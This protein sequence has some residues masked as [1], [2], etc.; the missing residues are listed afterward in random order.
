MDIYKS[1]LAIVVALFL[2][3]PASTEAQDLD[4]GR[5]N[6]DVITVWHRLGIPQGIGR[7]KKFRD[8]RV[9]RNGNRPEKERKPPLKRLADEQFLAED[10]NPLLKEAAKIKMDQDLAP[11]K[12]KALKYISSVGCS[13]YNKATA[14]MLEKALVAGME[15][16]SDEVRVAAVNVV[17]SN[18][19]NACQCNGQC[20]TCCSK[21]IVAK[22]QEIAFK[23]KPDG[24]FVEPNQQVRSLAE[25]ALM[26]CPA[27]I[28]EAE[29]E[30]PIDESEPEPKGGKLVDPGEEDESDG[31]DD[32]GE[33]DRV[34]DDSDETGDASDDSE[35]FQGPPQPDDPEDDVIERLESE[36]VPETEEG[37]P[38]LD[39][40]T[41]R[42]SYP[43]RIKTVST[44]RSYGPAWNDPALTDLKILGVIGELNQNSVEVQIEFNKPFEIPVGEQVVV[45]INEYDASFG[46]VISSKVGSARVRVD[47]YKLIQNLGVSKR[48]KLGVLVNN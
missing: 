23:T 11:Q 40:S 47:D 43:N 12:L 42:N 35:E 20:E 2:L 44:R 16:C 46:T 3:V 19:G 7:V 39:G 28:E 38:D 33:S 26:R 13:C 34:S 4:S 22:L 27:I 30:E 45:A 9:N 25:M 36:L 31:S 41:T 37:G 17:I 32:D 14:G 29:P 8:S 48:I 24:C 10:A 6:P 18:L 1:K 21:G 15:D 5:F